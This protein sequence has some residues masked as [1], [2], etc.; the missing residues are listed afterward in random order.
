VLNLKIDKVTVN[1]DL[2]SPLV[3]NLPL[4]DRILITVTN[5]KI[6]TGEE[7]DR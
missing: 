6:G 4:P 5:A 2:N 7:Y 3:V 1:L